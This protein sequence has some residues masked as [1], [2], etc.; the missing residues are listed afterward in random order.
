[1][2]L[3]SC[4]MG[5]KENCGIVGIFGQTDAVQTLYLG[6]FALQHRGQESAGIIVSNGEKISSHRGMGL[7]WEVFSPQNLKNLQGN[8]GIAHVRYS[9]TGSSSEKNIQPF[10]IEYQGKTFAIA[11]N[12]NLTNSFMLRKKLEEKGDIFQT[13]LD[14]EIIMHLLVRSKKKT[15]RGKM[16]D[17]FSKLQGAFSLLLFTQKEIVAIRDPWG[18]KPLCLGK[19]NNGYMVASE[20]CAFDLAGAKYIREI[21][22]GEIL[23]INKNG[24]KSDFLKTRKISHCIFEFIYFSRPDSKIFGESVYIA[25]KKLGEKLAEE[26]PFK[27]DIVIPIPDSGNI[28]ALGFANK[29]NLPFEMGIV[30][31][32]YVGRTFIQPFQS[33][34]ELG[35]KIKLNPIKEVLKGKKIIV[36]EDSIVRGTTSKTR[37]KNL[38]EAGAKKI[39]MGVT[40]PPIKF[41]CFYGIDFPGKKELIA[42]TKEVEEIRKSIGL[43]GL[44]YLS[45]K[46]MLSSMNI[47]PGNFCTACFTGQYRVKPE[48]CFNKNQFE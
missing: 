18:W 31:N 11:H 3:V 34:R 22:P 23:I 26:F 47:P 39:Y 4:S 20:S 24:L 19:I 6:L 25:R 40:C 38:R 16:I 9:T 36:I 13:S 8:Y 37:I 21:E 30:R 17:A 2:G 10:Q 15:L 7:V 48:R 14:T 35:V 44:Y 1:M 41:P 42:S 46:G 43:D 5:I 33:S 45:L 27:G 12:G 28:S 32:H 29:K